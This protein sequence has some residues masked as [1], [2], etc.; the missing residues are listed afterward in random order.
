MWL[1]RARILTLWLLALLVAASIGLLIAANPAHADTIIRVNSME[2]AGDNNPGNGTCATAPFLVGTEPNCTLRAA[3]QEANAEG[4]SD[5][6][7]FDSALSGTITLT[8]GE[9]GIANDTPAND[10]IIQGPEAR[11]VTVSGNRASRVFHIKSGSAVEIGRLTITRGSASSDA[12]GFA[13]G[14]GIY[15]DGGTLTVRSSTISDSNAIA[16]DTSSSVGGG[17]YNV[18][19]TLTLEN[20]TVSGNSA[21][22]GGGIFN[23]GG[24]LRLTSST[25]SEN[26]AT[27]TN[28][29]GGGVI[30]QEGTLTLANTIVARNERC[31][32]RARYTAV[33]WSRRDAH[34]P[35]L[36]PHR[37]HH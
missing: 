16:T 35:G 15:N 24:T 25:V 27:T 37:G 8:L 28:S 22:S 7:T 34:Q 33:E 17:I 12:S 26:T 11:N 29:S 10:L 14:G 4:D 21:R 13:A 36:Q 30:H 31:Q 32:H 6:V 19:G 3:I 2:D 20:T 5:T 9:L 1:Q 18:G 23:N